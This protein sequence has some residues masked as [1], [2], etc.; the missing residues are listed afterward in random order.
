MESSSRQPRSP[1]VRPRHEVQPRRAAI[2]RRRD[3]DRALSQEAVRSESL[4]DRSDSVPSQGMPDAERGPGSGKSRTLA[5]T[6]PARRGRRGRSRKQRA[7]ARRP[8]D[9]DLCAVCHC[10][11]RRRRSPEQVRGVD[12]AHL[13]R[14]VCGSRP[15]TH[16]AR[17]WALRREFYA[18]R[19]KVTSVS[20]RRAGDRAASAA[21][22][23]HRMKDSI[24]SAAI[25]IRARPLLGEGTAAKSVSGEGTPRYSCPT[26]SWRVSGPQPRAVFVQRVPPGA[27]Q[28]LFA[29][30]R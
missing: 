3:R 2:A 27:A 24:E 14:S 16:V 11:R 17:T 28:R 4:A 26:R 15:P 1:D 21:P 29:S 25:A 6:V 7:Q 12:S 23:P 9:C 13:N 30:R 5:L 22:S 10:E 19:A 20:D 18:S 8:R